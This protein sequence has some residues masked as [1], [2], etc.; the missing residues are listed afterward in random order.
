MTNMITGDVECQTPEACIHEKA[1]QLDIGKNPVF[2]WQWK[3]SDPEFEAALNIFLAEMVEDWD[4]D[5]SD[6]IVVMINKSNFKFQFDE[7]GFWFRDAGVRT[8]VFAEF[9]VLADGDIG[10]MPLAFQPFF[11][12]IMD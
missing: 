3:S 4:Y 12:E 1:H 5:Y 10:N 6:F 9:I 8:E 7:F 2:F 11:N